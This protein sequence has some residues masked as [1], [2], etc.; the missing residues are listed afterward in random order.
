MVSTIVN[1]RTVGFDVHGAGVSVTADDDRAIGAITEFLEP[2]ETTVGARSP[3][4]FEVS[5]SSEPDQPDPAAKP[6]CDL[7]YFAV[8]K[9]GSQRFVSA[10]RYGQGVADLD[11][12]GARIWTNGWG[13][14]YSWTTT[15]LLF[16]PLWAMLL[17]TTGRFTVHAAGVAR[18]GRA[19]LFPTSSG[20]GKSVLTMNLVRAGYDLLGDDTQ[21]LLPHANG[22]IKIAGFAEKIALRKGA[23]RFFPEL[24]H[25]PI[26]E[27]GRICVD[28]WQSGI[29]IANEPVGPGIIAFPN[30]T[31][32]HDSSFE[33]VSES[34]ALQR[35]I[36][37]SF[38]FTD[39]A[40]LDRH[41]AALSSLVSGSR[42]FRLGV[43]TDPHSLV[44][45]VRRMENES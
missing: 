6:V 14:N 17:K 20:G 9:A 7:D 42:C 13:E 37:C 38:F 27:G 22:N 5:T 11:T 16:L 19:L 41:L 18:N 32:E 15:R 30:L 25:E 12:G 8:S 45:C 43:G 23:C 26:G 1:R 40:M 34:Q 36:L 2:F 21:F 24:A 35:L 4:R 28:P 31:G 33:A 3:V 29:R 10:K 44:D 39:E